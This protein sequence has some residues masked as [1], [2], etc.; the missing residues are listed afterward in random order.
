MIEW[1]FDK[2]NVEKKEFVLIPVG[3]YKIRVEDLT[4]CQSQSGNQYI[5][6]TF[7]ISGYPGKLWYN[8]TFVK[9]EPARTNG[10]ILA[11]SDSFGITPGDFSLASWKG[12]IGACHVKHQDGY[13]NISYFIPKHKQDKLGC[14]I[15]CSTPS[16]S[17][18][19]PF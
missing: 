8:L 10:F 2:N 1:S 3:D 4:E 14:W 12:K 9:S 11:I 18:D 13:A 19:I 15:E 7:D 16:S 6:F 5:K 17:S